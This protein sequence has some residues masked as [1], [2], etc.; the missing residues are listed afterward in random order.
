MYELSKKRVLY[1]G[2][3]TEAD[4]DTFE[5]LI[6]DFGKDKS[7]VFYKG[8]PIVGPRPVSFRVLDEYYARDIERVYT[9]SARTVKTFA[10]DNTTFQ[11]LGFGFARDRTR[12]F[13]RG[14]RMRADAATLAPLGE[15]LALDGKGV[16]WHNT[17][18][19]DQPLS[20]TGLRFEAGPF[21]LYL[22]NCNHV[23]HVKRGGKTVRLNADPSTFE[24]L[25]GGYAREALHHFLEEKR[26]D[27]PA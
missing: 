13:W 6:Y 21:G 3:T 24:L 27:P 15:A 18:V 4:P 19:L 26:V 17:R 1:R 10:A 5:E 22:W 12:A 7:S 11:I 14:K 9:F 25:T 16:Y 23:W 2:K 8:V 20:S